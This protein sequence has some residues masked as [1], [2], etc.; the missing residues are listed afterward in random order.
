MGILQRISTL[1]R[2]NLNDLLDRAE[3]PEKVL[4]QMILDMEESVREGKIA[5]AAAIAEETKLKAAYEENLKKAQEWLEKA[6]LAVEKGEEDLARE[7]LR[8]RKTAEQ[9]AEAAKAQWEEQRRVCAQLRENLETLESRVADA[10]ARKDLLIARKKRA[11]AAK[12]VHEQL[13]GLTRA[14]SAFETF[15]KMEE[16]IESLEAQAQ[17]AAQ[18]QR[19]SLEERLARL[20]EDDELE[21]DLAALKER[22][23]QKKSGGS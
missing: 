17:A 20:G 23:A 2:A 1:I 3:D 12:K 22:V 8:R 14:Q 6:E 5:L 21:E 18:V 15:E 9:N 4:K 16:K 7:A 13:A 11:E 10:K 19:D